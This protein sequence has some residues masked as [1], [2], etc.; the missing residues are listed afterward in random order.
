MKEKNRE[1]QMLKGGSLLLAGFSFVYFFYKSIIMGAGF[2]D[3]KEYWK[4]MAYAI[5]G[6]D[7]STCAA[8]GILLDEIGVIGSGIV[9][10]WGRLLGNLIYPG[11]LPLKSVIIYYYCLLGICTGLAGWHIL[12]WIQNEKVKDWQQRENILFMLCLLAAPLYWE[13]ALNSGNMGG[14]LCILLILAAFFIGKCDWFAAF[15]IAMAM[16]K[17]QN[18]ALFMLVLLMKKKFKMIFQIIGIMLAGMV[19]TEIYVR[20]WSYFRGMSSNTSFWEK[21]LLILN[22]YSGNGQGTA[23]EGTLPFFTY[24]ILDKLIE[25]GVNAYVVLV[26]SAL[27]GIV[28]VIGVVCYMRDCKELREDWAVLFSI[29]ALGSIFWC[30]KTPCDEIIIILCNLLCVLYWKY[31]KR[32]W[33]SVLWILAYIFCINMKVFRFWG[34][35]ILPME[36]DT[37]VVA[38]QILRIVVYIAMV[39]GIKKRIG[40]NSMIH[41]EV[42]FEGK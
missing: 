27:L 6:Y 15:L 12:K 36:F 28:F 17:P 18:A 2:V 34:R 8:E 33:K 35:K 39:V 19:S 37:A 31:G 23:G 29:A 24:G 9:F 42:K 11:F 7:I 22:G 10:P 21:I 13:D 20:I 40:K 30:Y 32:D 14:L 5:R 16:I 25:F 3:I 26:G 1:L 4:Y 38:D 41:R